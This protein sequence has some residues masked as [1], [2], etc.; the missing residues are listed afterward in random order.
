[1]QFGSRKT[2]VLPNGATLRE[3]YA[4]KH[5]DV[6]GSIAR[7][8][9][10][11]AQEEHEHRVKKK[12]DAFVSYLDSLQSQIEHDHQKKRDEKE[13]DHR[14]HLKT[15][16]EGFFKFWDDRQKFL[17]QKA[18]DED[19]RF[20]Q[21]AEEDIGLVEA[22]KR[23]ER[24]VDER[25]DHNLMLKARRDQEED[26]LK[27]RRRR[28]ALKTQ[29][30]E[31]KRENDALIACR[32]QRQ[33]EEWEEEVRLNE[34]YDQM[35][36]EMEDKRVAVVREREERQDQ[37]LKRIQE[38][39]KLMS[40]Y[41]TSEE[42]KLSEEIKAIQEKE[43]QK[44][45]EKDRKRREAMLL[46]ER[47]IAEQLREK[48]RRK[49]EEERENMAIAKYLRDKDEELERREREKQ[50]KK[51]LAEEEYL[52]DIEGQIHRARQRKFRELV[53][54]MTP[55]EQSWQASTLQRAQQKL[56]EKT[57]S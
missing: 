40:S 50:R 29:L 30:E 23:R 13:R 36:Q 41:F 42:T 28:E 49:E 57:H 35:M 24:E 26:R 21:L 32:K 33:R 6:W 18:I 53:G 47:T 16:E 46:Q 45:R 54:E 19:V 37:A 3:V 20:R 43:D 9:S 56:M 1:M 14:E 39:E 17:R 15:T 2:I 55:R 31:T 34:Q 4:R 25:I 51:R 8:Q 22:R 7:L 11:E 52:R 38:I 48:Q 27:Q 5:G 12:K 10:V 44:Q